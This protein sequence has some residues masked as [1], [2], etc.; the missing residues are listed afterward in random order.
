MV[1]RSVP[2]NRDPRDLSWLDLAAGRLRLERLGRNGSQST[3]FP[4]RQC[5]HSSRSNKA[6]RPPSSA[7]L[8]LSTLSASS[9]AS[10]PRHRQL[11]FRQPCEMRL[12]WGRRAG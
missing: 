1:F 2:I 10:G 3:F 4:C 8:R 5:R 6:A 12:S 11:G 9:L 7:A